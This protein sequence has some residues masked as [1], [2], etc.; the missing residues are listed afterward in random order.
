MLPKFEKIVALHRDDFNV[1]DQ[2]RHL[3]PLEP[4]EIRQLIHCVLDQV[5]NDNSRKVLATNTKQSNKQMH[6]CNAAALSEPIE[7]SILSPFTSSVHK[8]F[9]RLFTRVSVV[10]QLLPLIPLSYLLL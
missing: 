7:S 9:S 1:S 8:N 3:E 2:V 6:D 4:T 10:S 5:L